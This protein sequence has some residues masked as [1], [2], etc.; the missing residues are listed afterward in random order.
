MRNVGEDDMTET[1]PIA[2]GHSVTLVQVVG[3]ALFAT[4]LVV[5]ATM[6]ALFVTGLV[7]W[8]R[9]GRP[10]LFGW[11]LRNLSACTALLG[12]FSFAAY[13]TRTYG[14]L[15]VAAPDQS[16]WLSW[17]LEAN[18]RLAMACLVA[19]IGFVLG[20]VLGPERK[21]NHR[22]PSVGGAAVN[23]APQR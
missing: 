20:T 17:Q 12:I 7:A 13:W 18:G 23:R 14:V 1:I 4:L 6:L 10:W 22:Q 3:P 8:T 9:S 11:W 5:A 2:E 15:H 16:L 21:Q 19:L